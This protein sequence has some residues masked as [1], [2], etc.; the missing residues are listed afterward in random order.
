LESGDAETWRTAPFYFWSGAAY[1]R[2]GAHEEAEKRLARCIELEPDHAAALNYLAYLWADRGV[3]LDEAHALISRALTI[4]PEEAA[5]IDT[6]GWIQFRKGQFPEALET[7][8]RALARAPDEAEIL[9]HVGDALDRMGREADALEHWKRAF[10]SDPDL[11]G[12]RDKLESQGVNPVP[13]LEKAGEEKI[14]RQQAK[15]AEFFEP[16]GG[17]LPD[18]GDSA[19][20]I[21][22]LDL[23]HDDLNRMND[24][25]PDSGPEPETY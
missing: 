9:D 13:L 2:T 1:E 5:F 16:A 19:F 8:L 24:P 17:A 6:L 20:P 25:F 12:L 3:R 10:I 18:P 7:L 23:T 11:S 21:P 22:G 14:R 4:L 15:E